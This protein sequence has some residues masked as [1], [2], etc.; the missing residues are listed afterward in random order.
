MILFN[1]VYVYLC[2]KCEKFGGCWRSFSWL[3]QKVT[4]TNMHAC[5]VHTDQEDYYIILVS[6]MV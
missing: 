1:V 2:K 4:D 3:Y 5:T 6:K